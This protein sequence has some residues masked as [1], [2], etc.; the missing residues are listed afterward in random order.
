MIVRLVLACLF[1]SLSACTESSS[2]A[3]TMSDESIKELQIV[4]VEKG[5]G[6]VATAGSVVSV[7]YTGWL[8]DPSAPE[9][10]GKKFDSSVDRGTPLDFP[11]GKGRVIPG[12]D[13]GIEGMMVGGKQTLIIPPDMAYGSRGA[14]GV[15][16]PNATL[17]F[18]VELVAVN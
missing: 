4:N 6:E 10:K 18:D 1:V 15:I 11:L 13:Q 14:G 7:H 8:Y 5:Q 12:W 17:L 16:P 2:P 9:G 3:K